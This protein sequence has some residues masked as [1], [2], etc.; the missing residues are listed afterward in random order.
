[1]MDNSSE[2]ISS[3]IIPRHYFEVCL[4]C[5]RF[6]F[7]RDKKRMQMFDYFQQILRFVI[8][9]CS[10]SWVEEGWESIVCFTWV[11]LLKAHKH[12]KVMYF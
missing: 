2:Y 7:A 8:V 4:W 9:C 3:Q 12:G 11:Y 10:F 5:P 1:M 6:S